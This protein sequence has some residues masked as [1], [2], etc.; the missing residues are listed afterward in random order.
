MRLHITLDEE[1]VAELDRRVGPRER[2]A[3]IATAVRRALAD[4]RHWEAIEQSLG[5]VADHGHEWDDD[6]AAWV[7]AQRDT[8]VRRVG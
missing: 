7:R 8:D 4:Q 5:A 1:L 3:F 6:P 2:S